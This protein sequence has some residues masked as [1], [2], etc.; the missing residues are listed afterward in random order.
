MFLK[1]S[2]NIDGPFFSFCSWHQLCLV[3][4][5]YQ[6]FLLTIR[7]NKVLT[8]ENPDGPKWCWSSSDSGSYCNAFIK[9]KH[10]FAAAS[11][12]SSPAALWTMSFLMLE[13]C[14]ECCSTWQLSG[15]SSVRIIPLLKRVGHLQG[16]LEGFAYG[17]TSIW[18]WSDLRIGL[19]MESF[20]EMKADGGGW[21][22][23]RVRQ[24]LLW[25]TH[26]W[27]SFPTV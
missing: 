1:S 20:G 26:P 12:Q 19:P 4:T 24:C 17:W 10:L 25:L 11:P 15:P 13:I 2:Q 21:G 18:S 6:S 9:N 22:W 27:M 8:A 14:Q 16:R 23:W 7:Q 5:L 3:E